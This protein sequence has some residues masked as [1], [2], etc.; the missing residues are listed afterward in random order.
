LPGLELLDAALP[1]T[2]GGFTSRSGGISAAP[3]EQLNLALH[4][5]DVAEAVM[6]NRAGVAG[7]F[8][9]TAIAFPEQVHGPSVAVVDGPVDSRAWP[10]GAGCDAVVTVRPGVPLGVLVADCL[11]ILLTDPEARVIGAAHAG[12]RGLAEGVI[13]ATL[14]AMVALG[15]EPG[16]TAAVI[17]P[18]ICGRCY[19]VPEEMRDEVDAVVPGSACETSIGTSGLDLVAGALG[20]LSDAGV[21]AT[22]LGICTAEDEQF[23]SYR[24]EGV[25]GRFAGVVMIPG[26][27]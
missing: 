2:V 19:E 24:R 14:A 16:R 23:Y 25:T 13:Q 11:P 6:A 10:G 17:G 5:G 21:T 1:G 26:D 22:A 27:D 12:R 4:V 8:G 9:A 3:W 20:V 18:S 7:W 15:A